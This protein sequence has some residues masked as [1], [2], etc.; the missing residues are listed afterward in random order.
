MAMIGATSTGISPGRGYTKLSLA[1]ENGSLGGKLGLIDV[2]FVPSCPVNLISLDRLNRVGI[3]YNNKRGKLYLQGRAIGYVPHIDR[4]YVFSIVGN[5]SPL[6]NLVRQ[7]DGVYQGPQ[8][9]LY[10]NKAIPL[11]IWHGRLGHCGKDDLRR[12]L[13]RLQIEYRDD[14]DQR[15]DYSIG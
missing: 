15:G 8:T 14:I 13:K 6:V 5:P 2:W 7:E 3:F 4:S 10:S 9:V 11:S 1:L 12:Y